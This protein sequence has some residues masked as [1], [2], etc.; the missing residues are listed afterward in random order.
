ADAP[1]R[2]AEASVAEAL[3]EREPVTVVL[4]QKGWIRSL[5]GHIADA[6]SLSF[7]AEDRGRFVIRAE[8][9]ARLIALS[10]DGKAFTR[11][12]DRLPGG[13]GAGEPIRLMVDL[14]EGADI[15]AL[16]VFRPGARRLL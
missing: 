6:S 16:F 2:A 3:V 7:K 11:A 10:T 15:A 4:S 9:T 13:R 14:D 12:A 8:T 5:K 1:D